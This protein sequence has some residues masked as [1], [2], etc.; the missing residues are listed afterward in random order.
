MGSSQ[1]RK[2]VQVTKYV[3]AIP[4]LRYERYLMCN[5]RRINQSIPNAML[6]NTKKK[7]VYIIYR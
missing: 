3:V 4:I 6:I 7:F 1:A 2:K 5:K